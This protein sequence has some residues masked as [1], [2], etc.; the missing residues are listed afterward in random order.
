M[1]K[2][3]IFFITVL[4][5]ILIVLGILQTPIM[6]SVRQTAWSQWTMW[7]ASLF[8]IVGLTN[9]ED[10]TDQLS[11]LQ[12]ENIRLKAEL[13]DY[14]QLK[15]QL[16]TPAFGDFHQ[17]QAHVAGRPIDTL[18]SQLII[19]KGAQDGITLHAPVII[20]NGVIVGLVS[21]V[22]ANSATITSLYHPST[23]LPV[24][25]V[26]DDPDKAPAR[27]L[28]KSQSYSQL[29]VTTIPRN[30][31]LAEQTEFVTSQDANSIPEGLRVG[32]VKT[33]FN[34]QQD[35]YQEAVLQAPYDI[36]QIRAVT[37]LVLP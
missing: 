9:T 32:T 31:E 30:Y 25:S 23:A 17:V 36:D 13:K 10:I 28:L 34:D 14:N 16:S 4:L 22:Q 26:S 12:T 6:R 20:N 29:R 8:G 35:A 19:N 27:G 18:Q 33:I 21:D 15:Q 3:T 1:T 5:V 2:R 24:V 37:V 11:Q 7:Q